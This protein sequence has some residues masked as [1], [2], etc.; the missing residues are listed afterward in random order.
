MSFL[1]YASGQTDRQTD[2]HT[3]RNTSHLSRG[4]SSVISSTIVISQLRFQ[5]QLY[6]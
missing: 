4:P 3:D 5:L 2:R 1:G 6:F